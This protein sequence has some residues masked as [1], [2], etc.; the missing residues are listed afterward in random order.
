MGR[1][2]VRRNGYRC[3]VIRKGSVQTPAGLAARFA[4]LL[5]RF[6]AVRIRKKKTRAICEG[7]PLV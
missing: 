7:V 5:R 2:V 1:F 6:A 4:R 3:L